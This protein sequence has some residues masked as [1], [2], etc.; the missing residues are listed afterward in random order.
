MSKEISALKLKIKKSAQEIETL[1]GQSRICNWLYNHLLEKAFELKALFKSTQDRE[2]AK[3]LYTAR[4]LRNLLPAIKK[5]YPFLKVVHSSVLK[6]AALRLSE[7]IRMHQ[8]SKKTQR[9]TGWPK[10]RAWKS[11]WFSLFYDE[12]TK[13]FFAQGDKLTLSLGMGED[14]KQRSIELTLEESYLLK[15]KNIKNLRIVSE[16]G[17]YYAVFTI[18]Q[19][20]KKT[21]PLSK[22]IALDPNHKNFAYGVDLEGKA[23][24]IG[25]LTWL[26]NYDKQID[27]L[28][29]KRDKCQKKAHKCPVLDTKGQPTDKFYYKPSQRWLKYQNSLEQSYRK[30]R[31]QTKTFMFTA[32]H[33]LV[34]EYD[35]VGIGDYAPSGNGITPKMRRSMNN[36]SLIGKFK[37][38]LSWVGK[39][40][41]KTIIIYDEKGTTRT[42]CHCHREVEGGLHPSIRQWECSGCKTQHIRDE[43]AAIN[44]LDRIL[45]DLTENSGIIFPQVSCSDLVVKQ[46]CAW[47]V[48]TSGVIIKHRGVE[49]ARLSR[50]GKKLN[51]ESDFSRPKVDQFV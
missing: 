6:N 42:C 19:E 24:E 23:L 2:A 32:A 7:S 27:E 4:G 31:E 40:S 25:A 17:D 50:N 30:R 15:D 48:S 16:L 5:E 37:E 21:K 8:K 44:G 22:I 45:S 43:N 20:A 29:A 26:K 12:P 47:R 13:G 33:R 28:K 41:G 49:T 36:R 39:K 34:A 3:K 10:Y 9:K 1:D 51:R 46:R 35:C 18:E 38:V 14:R 11:H